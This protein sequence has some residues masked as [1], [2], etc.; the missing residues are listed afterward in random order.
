MNLT[1]TPMQNNISILKKLTKCITC[2]SG[3]SAIEFALALPLLLLLLLLGGVEGVRTL[4][5]HQKLERTAFSMA[6]LIAQS[7]D[8]SRIEIDLIF[9]AVSGL[10]EPF[11][12]NTNGRIII[13]SIG[14]R[15]NSGAIVNWR[16]EGAGYLGTA[17]SSMGDVGMA[18]T[19]LPS[20]FTIANGEDTIVAEIFFD[21]EPLLIPGLFPSNTVSKQAFFRPRLGALDTIQD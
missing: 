1:I 17:T 5:L 13:T 10:M 3:I 14:N 16:H 12:F 15:D 20:G 6:N 7:Q 2:N 11:D 19:N 8:I 18:A 4:M 21:A 9:N